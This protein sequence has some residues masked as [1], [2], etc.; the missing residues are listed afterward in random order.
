MPRYQTTIVLLLLISVFAVASASAARAQAICNTDVPGGVVV[1]GAGDQ[2]R[3]EKVQV[4]TQAGEEAATLRFALG[5]F[6]LGFMAQGSNL[7]L[8]PR[9]P[10]LGGKGEEETSRIWY[11]LSGSRFR[12]QS[13]RV[14]CNY[15][16]SHPVIV[17]H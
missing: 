8:T 9:P 13:E 11:I 6:G 17:A 14:L 12:S 7:Y 10:S 1:G 15:A 16:L 2:P 3:A 4:D 5:Q